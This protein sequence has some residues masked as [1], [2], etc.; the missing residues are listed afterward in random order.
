[1]E[2]GAGILTAAQ[3]QWVDAMQ[4]LRTRKPVRHVRPPRESGLR[5]KAY[6]LVTAPAFDAFIIVVIV[7]N[8][9]LMSCDYWGIENN[10]AIMS[11]YNRAM[12]TFNCIYYAECLM[13]LFS[14]G[15]RGYFSDLWCCFDFF[16]VCTSLVDQF[17]SEFL[18]K[19]LPMPPMLLRVLRIFRILR[20]LRL[21]RHAKGLRDLI[22]TMVLSFPALINV[23]SLLALILFIYAVLGRQLFALL[24]IPKQEVGEALPGGINSMRNFQSFSSSFL[25][26]FQ[27]LTGD[28][29]STIMS[30]AMVDETSGRCSHEQRNCGS[31]AAIPFFITFQIIGCFVFVN[32]IVAVILENFATLH[33]INPAL[34][35]SGDLELFGEAWAELDPDGDGYI[36]LD[37]LPNLFMKL[38]SP[39]GMKGKSELRATQL[40]MRLQLSQ[41]RDGEVRFRDVLLELI[42]NNYFRSGKLNSTEFYELAPVLNVPGLE[43]RAPQP[44]RTALPVVST[45]FGYHEGSVASIFAIRVLHAQAKDMLM[46]MLARAQDRIALRSKAKS[47]P[48]KERGVSPS[49][50]ASNERG[51]SIRA[52]KDVTRG[53]SDIPSQSKATRP[54]PGA[55][56]VLPGSR[57]L[58]APVPIP[59]AGGVLL[60]ESMQKPV[61]SCNGRIVTST[62]VTTQDDIS[63]P[64]DLFLP[65]GEGRAKQNGTAH[66]ANRTEHRRPGSAE[67]KRH[68][69]RQGSSDKMPG[70]EI[71]RPIHSNGQSKPPGSNMNLPSGDGYMGK[72]IL[73]PN[74][75]RSCIV[76]S[77]PTPS[78]PPPHRPSRRAPV[79]PTTAELERLAQAES[80][81][82]ATSGHFT[83]LHDPRNF[84]FPGVQEVQ[85]PL[86]LATSLLQNGRF[87]FSADERDC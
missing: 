23:G 15:V 50:K 71:Q 20:I 69:T 75:Q 62:T 80:A 81:A 12:I 78:Q 5:R 7:A 30:D 2:S 25:L 48:P 39:M 55:S 49:R 64:M 46:A 51:K 35:S 53:K 87:K 73:D 57:A 58:P 9:M 22:V 26:L 36:P 10:T 82:M 42:D 67:T 74:G 17:A 11:T 68:R 33:N 45:G 34:I 6:Y 70:M 3:K 19:V 72:F 4:A 76:T 40:C 38:P 59:L 27:C 56:K 18:A 63:R 41:T 8:I 65:N 86:D 60:H 54:T 28:G 29:W 44:G 24:A 85:S 43:A 13:K 52:T 79:S 21:L 66:K 47:S 37:T 31:A 77:P 16:L 84:G 32:L 1:M 61:A 14:L 83:S